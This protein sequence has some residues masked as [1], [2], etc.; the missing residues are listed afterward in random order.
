MQTKF[1]ILFFRPYK[2]EALPVYGQ[3]HLHINYSLKMRQTMAKYGRL[4]P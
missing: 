2:D 4:I 3:I 1:L